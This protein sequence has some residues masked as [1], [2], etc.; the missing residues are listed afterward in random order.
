MD[1]SGQ[2]GARPV[3][4][5]AVRPP[6]ADA[7]LREAAR[8]AAALGAELV[9]AHVDASRFAVAEHP[10]GSI[11]SRAVDPDLADERDGVFDAALAAGIDALLAGSGVRWSGR[12]LAGAPAHALARL[13]EV[14]QARM[15]VVGTRENTVRDG[16]R[17][18]FQGSVAAQ[19]AHRQHRPVLVVPLHPVGDG[20]PLP[21]E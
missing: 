2:A 14:V 21:W 15:I 13:A 20:G 3:I 16:L 11:V 12:E 19:L 8:M 10:D 6:L 17:E 9:C 4:L 1:A 18:F 5:V 7:V